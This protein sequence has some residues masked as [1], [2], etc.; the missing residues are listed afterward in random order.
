MPRRKQPA[1]PAWTPNQIVA[2]NIAKA[3]LLR[4]WTQDQ[5][6]EACAPYLGSRLSPASWSALERSVDGGRIRE[7]TADELIGFARGFALPV[8]FFLTPPSVWDSHVVNTPDAGPDGLEPIE[9]FDVVIGTT[10]SLAEWEQY[11]LSWPSPASRVRIHPDGT[12]ENLGR[13]Q[14]DVHPRLAGPAAMRAQLLLREQF[15]DIVRAR[16]V[17][18]RLSATLDLLDEPTSGGINQ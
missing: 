6:A 7:I 16:D 3:R 4:G 15:G 11:L 10:E 5:A 12:M 2:H 9:L 13:E 14:P 8:G 18:N 1:P 17:L